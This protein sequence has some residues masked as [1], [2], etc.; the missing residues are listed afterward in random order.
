MAAKKS[1]CLNI[2]RARFRLANHLLGLRT[3]SNFASHLIDSSL[4]PS[5][6]EPISK[7][8]LINSPGRMRKR[9][10]EKSIRGMKAER[11]AS[12]RSQ[13]WS[14]FRPT[15]YARRLILRQRLATARWIGNWIVLMRFVRI[16]ILWCTDPLSIA[17]IQYPFSAIAEV[18]WVIEF[19][20]YPM[21]ASWYY[22]GGLKY[23]S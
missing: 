2:K 21:E 5:G 14:L 1:S 4:P 6:Q 11:V 23:A 10:R 7:S 9:E 19:F 18:I 12:W 15:R 8:L 22:R 13:R 20:W 16:K 17:Q 3:H